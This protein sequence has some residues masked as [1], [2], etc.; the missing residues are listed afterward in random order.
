MADTTNYGWT[1]PTVGGSAD[2]WGGLVNTVFDDIDTDLKAVSDAAAGKMVKSQNL[3]DVADKA[4]SRIN[5]GV[6][7]GADVQAYSARLGK[8]AALSL[9]AGRLIYTTA[10][11]TLGTSV[12][13]DW[14]RT[15]L[16]NGSAVAARA[17]LGLG[18]A[19]TQSTGTSGGNIPL[20][21]GN[22]TWSGNQALP[23]G[24]TYNGK[25]IAHVDSGSATNSGRISWGTSAPGT[26][27][28]GEIYLRHA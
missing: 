12:L 10:S 18:S 19:A 20:L 26:L 15:F 3:D 21:S 11:E 5:L 27:A 14:G 28:V 23:A 7:I 24:S 25:R 13:V 16:A 17:D 6:E 8:Y 4:Q 1:K 9:P 22:N 2:T